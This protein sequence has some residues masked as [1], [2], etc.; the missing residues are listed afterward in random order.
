MNSKVSKESDIIFETDKE[1]LKLEIQKQEKLKG[2]DALNKFE[3]NVIN[4]NTI[5][6][7]EFEIVDGFYNI[8]VGY[9][10]KGVNKSFWERFKNAD[11]IYN[12]MCYD[13]FQH[14]YR[15]IDFYWESYTKDD[16]ELRRTNFKENFL[17]KFIDGESYISL[18]Y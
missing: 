10:R 9:Q 18:S 8:E 16:V 15:S 7:Y 17:E 14:V 6:Y 12:F 3:V 11:E 1:K 4:W 13:D 5:N 2:L